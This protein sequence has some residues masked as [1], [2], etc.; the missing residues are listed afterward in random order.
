MKTTWN[1]VHNETG[2]PA[3]KN[4]FHSLRIN[5]RSV[6][7]QRSIANEFNNY[8]LNIAGSI[9]NSSIN[10]KEDASPLNNLFKILISHSVI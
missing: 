6:Y 10:E 9:R 5:N 4:N 3:N 8:F 2:T 7:N 1:I